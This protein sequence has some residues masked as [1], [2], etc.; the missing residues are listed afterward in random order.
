MVSDLENSVELIF[1]GTVPILAISVKRSKVKPSW[2]STK[3]FLLLMFKG[4][5]G[6]INKVKY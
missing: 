2:A 4:N 1:K 3:S 6:T 5:D